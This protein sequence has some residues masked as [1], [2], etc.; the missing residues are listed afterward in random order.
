MCVLKQGVFSFGFFACFKRDFPRCFKGS[1]G[2]SPTVFI[3]FLSLQ[4]VVMLILLD[5]LNFILM[6]HMSMQMAQQ[7]LSK[8][9]P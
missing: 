6:L 7:A 1:L 8:S 5:S 2:L 4:F 9:V 3:S